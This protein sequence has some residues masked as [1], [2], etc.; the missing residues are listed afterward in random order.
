M[1]RVCWTHWNSMTW[2]DL[3]RTYIVKA[4]LGFERNPKEST[5]VTNIRCTLLSQLSLGFS[6]E[7]LVKWVFFSNVQ[8][9]T[10]GFFF[11]I[12]VFFL[13]ITSMCRFHSRIPTKK[14]ISHSLIHMGFIGLVTWSGVRGLWKTGLD[15]LKECLRVILSKNLK[16]VLLVPFVHF[17]FW[18]G[19]YSFCLV[20]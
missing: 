8:V 3:E 15:R 6:H 1:T 12:Y 7:L 4:A 11:L 16:S 19:L 20:H 9:W 13:T 14:Q 18:A 2:V 17:N 5:R 10:S